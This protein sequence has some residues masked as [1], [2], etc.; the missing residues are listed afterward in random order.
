MYY[1]VRPAIKTCFRSC[2]NPA[3]ARLNCT[4]TALVNE[5]AL[6]L[7]EAMDL[8]CAAPAFPLYDKPT[9]LLC[10]QLLAPNATCSADVLTAA[11]GEKHGPSW[12][13]MAG[14]VH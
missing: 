14:V 5:L 6:S 13:V 2:L 9:V 10:P 12:P 1:V 11:S 8:R 7:T 4:R 3:P